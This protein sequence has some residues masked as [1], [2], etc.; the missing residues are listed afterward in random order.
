MNNCIHPTGLVR[1]GNATILGNE[2]F[3]LY[4]VV[5][6]AFH[7]I[8]SW[9]DALQL[10]LRS[11]H[12]PLPFH[13]P[14]LSLLASNDYVELSH[15]NTYAPLNMLSFA[16]CLMLSPS[17]QIIVHMHCTRNQLPHGCSCICSF[18]ASR[19]LRCN[20]KSRL[21]RAGRLQQSQQSL[22]ST[23]TSTNT[24]ILR[25]VCYPRTSLCN[26]AFVRSIFQWYVRLLHL[27]SNI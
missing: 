4:H 18:A 22:T 7:R 17:W 19:I 5:V 15:G 11:I 14:S 26:Y 1:G 6:V 23:S 16:I 8:V 24:N 25:S 12:A 21:E 3:R 20:F 27:W 13:S 2:R 10:L 9:H